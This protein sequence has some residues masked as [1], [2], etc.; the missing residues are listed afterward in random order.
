MPPATPTQ[1]Q[2]QSQET[3]A[4]KREV[5]AS[6]LLKKMGWAGGGGPKAPVAQA[7]DQRTPRPDGPREADSPAAGA[8]EGSVWKR[9]VK[10]GD[11]F[12]RREKAPPVPG[13][14]F[15]G[16][17]AE[18]VSFW[19]KEISLKDLLRAPGTQ[20]ESTDSPDAA[21]A[22]QPKAKRQKTKGSTSLLAKLLGALSSGSGS[23]RSPSHVPVAVP[24]TR[25]VNLIPPDL[26][27]EKKRAVGPAEIGVGI[28]AVAVVVGLFILSSGA[29]SDL[30]AAKERLA[31]VEA[32]QAQ[33]AEAASALASAGTGTTAS[34]LLGEEAARAS[35]L[36]NALG[37]RTAWDRVLRR[38]TVV[39]PADTWL[40]GLGGTSTTSDLALAAGVGTELAS[41]LTLTGY[42]LNRDGVA[43]LLSRMEAIPELAV[44]QLLAATQ[45]TLSGS[46]VIEYSITATLKADSGA[47]PVA[48]TIG[49]TP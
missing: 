22:A 2:P 47:P 17:E 14:A 30:D 35:A 36:S 46:A 23:R 3:S 20:T 15:S 24:L 40:R 41:T 27:L 43:K 39:M 38:I 16:A 8:H 25:S 10:A 6:D 31:A 33:L 32:E 12:R 19:K 45:T 11:L 42:S 21:S 37:S 7:S 29:S 26:A 13:D 5:R 18:P 48:N 49:L 9:E 28:A 1:P 34:P 44:V 4:W